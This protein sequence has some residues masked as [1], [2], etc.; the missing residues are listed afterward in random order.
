MI[1]VPWKT[2]TRIYL[3]RKRSA[4]NAA[5]WYPYLRHCL[6]WTRSSELQVHVPDLSVT[7]KLADPYR[8]LEKPPKWVDILE[9]WAKDER[10]GLAQKRYG[11]LDWVPGANE[12]RMH[13]TISVQKTHDLGLR[14]LSYD[15]KFRRWELLKRSLRP[16]KDSW[17]AF[18][19]TLIMI[20]KA[21][22]RTKTD[23]IFLGMSDGFT[24]RTGREFQSCVSSLNCLLSF[25]AP[26]SPKYLLMR[27]LF[28][29]R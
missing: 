26:A 10:M 21:H 29:L 17:S 22:A 13:G 23:R 15:R 11:L 20:W 18:P 7:L 27:S 19:K 12:Q 1:W 28:N 5:E 4:A 9:A 24:T 8:A 6:G 3:L 25:G 14:P 2:G 16:W